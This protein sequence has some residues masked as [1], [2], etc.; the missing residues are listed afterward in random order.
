MTRNGRTIQR[1]GLLLAASALTWGLSGC[2]GPASE[3]SGHMPAQDAP[4]QQSRSHVV[5]HNG[6]DL[7]FHVIDGR[8]PAIVLD[9]GGGEDSS[10]WSELAPKL[11]TE[12]GSMVIS[13]D[14]AG[15][16]ESDEVPG[17][18]N[19]A[20]AASD[21]EAGL[22]ELNV[23]KPYVLVAHSLSGEI[24]TDIALTH[25]DHIA[26]AVLID[27]S[28]PNFYT[29][30]QIDRI[31]AANEE[32]LEDARKQQSQS[33]EARQFIAH[34][35]NYGPTHRAYHQLTWPHSVPATVITSSETPF[36]ATRGDGAA[37]TQAQQQFAKAAPN[38]QL[39]L[40]DP[41]S[42]EIP[43]DRPEIVLQAIANAVESAE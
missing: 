31:V 28:L 38:R 2:A 17:P 24:A 20:D 36:S 18:W 33:R 22:A 43:R 27:A 41:S 26:G 39:I 42:H 6:H 25:P 13:Y 11:A 19:A 7:V 15:E 1:A 12:T 30:S 5:T 32:K 40:A 37:W 16:G 4:S 34:A 3:P 8:K 35:M 9:A 14:R 10:E 21:L 29:D 23:N